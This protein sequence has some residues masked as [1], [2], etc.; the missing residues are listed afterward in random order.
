M[1]NSTIW[2]KRGLFLLLALTILFGNLLPLS[3]VPSS[4]AGP[5][6]LIALTFAWALRRPEFVPVLLIA[7]IM[8]LADLLLQRPPGLMAALIVLGTEQLKTRAI[9]LRDASFVGEW[10]AAG[11][12]VVSVFLLNRVTLSVLM[13]DQAP[14]GLTLIQMIATILIYPV[15]VFVSHLF[16]GVRKLAPGDDDAIGSRI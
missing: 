9:G 11:L 2:W 13:V 8:L 3:T 16:F 1:A 12:V 6:L 14:L 7:F 5:D 4:W 10:V 15:V